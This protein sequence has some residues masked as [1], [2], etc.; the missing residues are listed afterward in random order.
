MATQNSFETK[1]DSMLVMIAE[2][3]TKIEEKISNFE[4]RLKTIDEKLSS[5][6]DTLDNQVKQLSQDVT[7]LRD[8]IDTVESS[9]KTKQISTE[10]HE[11]TEMMVSNSEDSRNAVL[12]RTACLERDNMTR[13]SYSK[14]IINIFVQGLEKSENADE[15]EEQIISSLNKF[16]TEPLELP[17]NS[18]TA[19]DL[20]WLPKFPV[21]RDGEKDTRPIIVKVLN[22]FE[23]T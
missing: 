18:I 14:R 15:T 10:L 13:D 8:R 3:L 2:R 6:C 9:N 17:W 16:L 1:I 22:N 4:L 12:N 21:R 7:K 20:Q 11:K 19:V 23:T 5:R